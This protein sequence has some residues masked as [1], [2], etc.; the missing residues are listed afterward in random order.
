[1]PDGGMYR[2]GEVAA[3]GA[4]RRTNVSVVLRHLRRHG[5]R[6][7]TEIA[8]D[9]GLPASTMSKLVAELV[10]LDLVTE[11]EPRRAGS[12]GRPHQALTLRT[13]VRCGLGVEISVNYVRAIAVDLSGDVLLDHRVPVEHDRHDHDATL[14]LTARLV[15][16]VL[17]RL[18]AAGTAVGGVTVAAPGRVDPGT[19]VVRHAVHLGWSDLPVGAELTARLGPDAPPLRVDNDARL[20]AVAEHRVAHAPSL[21][22]LTGEVG[23]AGGIVVDDTLVFGAAGSA[24][25][26]GHMPLD[27]RGTRC[28]CGQRGCFETMVGL[29]TFLSYAADRSDPVRDPHR[30]LED[31]LT[32]ITDRAAAGHPRTV[33][34][35]ARIAAD[36]GLGLGLLVNVLDPQVVVLGGYFSLLGE[37]LLGRVR[38]D[39]TGRVLAPQTGGCDVRLSR[40]GFTAAAR[41]AAETVLDTIFDNP[42]AGR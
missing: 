24:G 18:R 37:P 35:I 1:V 16:G 8:R 32:Q 38:A 36:L 22:Y 30:D 19:G 27:P 41:G 14:D 13:G 17:D 42:A 7:R 4:I 39:V 6:S 20:G 31:R 3:R 5:A 34:A 28:P 11:G 2:T 33:G 26:L 15:T 40:L 10:D 25:E 23:V 29:G 9:L 21:L 12:V